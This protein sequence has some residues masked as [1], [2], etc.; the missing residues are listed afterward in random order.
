[1]IRSERIRIEFLNQHDSTDFQRNVE[2][3]VMPPRLWTALKMMCFPNLWVGESYVAGSWYLSR[4]N[5]CDFLWTVRSEAPTKFRRYY[6]FVAAFRG[7][8]HYLEQYLLNHYYTRQVRSHYEVD[9][10]VYEK[11]LDEEMLYTCAFFE[12]GVSTLSEAQRNKVSTSIS[13]LG[14]GM[15]HTKVLDIGCG[16]GA[17][18]RALVKDHPGCDVCGLSISRN[19][20]QW[21]VKKDTIALSAEQSNRIEYRVEDYTRH[22][23]ENYY[24]AVLAIGMLEHVGL[25]GYDEFFLSL[26]KFL[27]P[28]GVALIH[29]IVAPKPARPTNRWVDRHIFTG[30]YAPAISELISAIERSSFRVTNIYVHPP[31]HYRKTIEY[32]LDNFSRNETSVAGFLMASGSSSSEAERF[33]RTWLFYLSG[34]RNMF[35]DGDPLSHQVV[36]VCIRKL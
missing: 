22:E 36:Q 12:N 32:W 25:G 14:L 31:N 28:T 21:A 17:V 5:L 11:I 35:S 7:F 3:V 24:D 20:I 9:S 19:Q 13:R 16:W 29:T 27:K 34:V 18:A 30:G 23:R 1:M 2:F 10:K 6:E 33:I 4:G 8:R 15:E 26:Y